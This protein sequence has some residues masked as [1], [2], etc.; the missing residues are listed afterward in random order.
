MFYPGKW[1]G[2]CVLAWTLSLLSA[3]A[4]TGCSPNP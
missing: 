2:R 1:L 3:N 4:V